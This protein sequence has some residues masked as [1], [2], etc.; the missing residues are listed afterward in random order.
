[1]PQGDGLTVLPRIKAEMPHLPILMF[2]GHDN[3]SFVARAVALGAAG[4]LRK[5][6][7]G[8]TLMQAIR[9][10]A[11]GRTIWN[12]ETLRRVTGACSSSRLTMDV[13]TPLTQRETEVLARLAE[14]LT[15]KDIAKALH[16]S[17]ETVKEHVQH[18]LL[19]IG[20]TDRTQAAI[21][22]VRKGIV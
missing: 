8:D 15:N 14:G 13:E 16:I 18:I 22:A 2:S 6:A 21:W 19:K 3:P 20:V 7:G 10:V 17:Y 4:Y 1:M 12:R 11:A 5:N 9:E